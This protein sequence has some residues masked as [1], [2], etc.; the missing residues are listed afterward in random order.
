MAL[1]IAHKQPVVGQGFDI[2]QALYNYINGLPAQFT[3]IDQASV[4]ANDGWFV[5]KS[6]GGTWECWL[7]SHSGGSGWANGNTLGGSAAG[8][9]WRVAYAFAPAGGWD[10]LNDTPATTMF[11][12]SALGGTWWNLMRACTGPNYFTPGE[13]QWLTIW[14]DPTTQMFAFLI[15][16]QRNN[17]WQDGLLVADVSSRFSGS[18]PTPYVVLGG[19]P[20]AL[21]VGSWLFLDTS[22]TSSALLLPG[23]ATQGYVV[24]DGGRTLNATN[25]P[26]PVTN[27]YDL[28]QFAIRSDTL[29]I[30]H[31]R[32]LIKSTFVRQCST[33]LGERTLVGDGNLGTTW[34]VPYANGGLALPWDGAI[35]L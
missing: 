5:F 15:D 20:S 6:F 7:G 10:A 26:N 25:Q 30:K 32:G 4:G 3:I 31:N 29:G 2:V 17:T 22:C 14:D 13:L 23:D 8:L 28:E 34:I 24:M 33:A 18:D 35:V 11:S 9:S 21:A 12:L 16:R 19:I 1:T 27:E